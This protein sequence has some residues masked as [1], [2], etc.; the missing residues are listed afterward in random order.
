MH[1]TLLVTSTLLCTIV[2]RPALRQ[3]SA[4]AGS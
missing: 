1:L 2:F 3:G 4:L